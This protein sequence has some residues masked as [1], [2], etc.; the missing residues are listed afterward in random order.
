MVGRVAESCAGGAGYLF[1]AEVHDRYYFV[2]RERPVSSCGADSIS[3]KWTLLFC[4]CDGSVARRSSEH[5]S[6]SSLECLCA[7]VPE[8]HIRVFLLVPEKEVTPVDISVEE[9]MKLI[10]SG[11]LYSP[12]PT[13][14]T[15]A[16][17][18]HAQNVGVEV[19]IA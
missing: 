8:S 11:G 3:E 13:A 5:F 10:V 18:P 15:L 19:P 12:P 6:R 17:R 9:A 4:V 7:D 1:Y 16:A 14:E 2:Q